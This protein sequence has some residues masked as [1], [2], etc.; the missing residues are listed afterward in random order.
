MNVFNKP[1]IKICGVTKISEVFVAFQCGAALI[2]LVFCKGS[3]RYL[4][5][6]K[7]KEIASFVHQLG[8]IPVGVFTEGSLEDIEEICTQVGL[9]V[10]Q[11]HG[12]Q[13]HSYVKILTQKKVCILAVSVS[14][15][16]K[17]DPEESKWVAFLNS[18]KDFVLFDHRLGGTG[19][20]FRWENFSPDRSYRWILAG[21]LNPRNVA[22]A[23]EYLKPSGVDVSSGV[24][25]AFFHGKD[26]KLIKEFIDKAKSAFTLKGGVS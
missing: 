20:P 19:V 7:A 3:K 1:L 10:V 4:E 23:I 6:N 15:D 16:G 21:G 26:P 8:A 11:L 9:N 14:S 24:E 25:Y 13:V 22:E 12:K 5:Q 2:G 17:I 18:E